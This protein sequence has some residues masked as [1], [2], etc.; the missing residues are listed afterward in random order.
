MPVAITKAT[1]DDI[2][3]FKTCRITVCSSTKG[4]GKSFF[5]MAMLYE[6]MRQ[7]AFD[8]YYV[9]I[10]SM[11][12]EENN[13]YGWLLARKDLTYS[14]SF[15]DALLQHIMDRQEKHAKSRVMLVMDDAT[16]WGS[17]MSSNLIFKQFITMSRHLRVNMVVAVHSL[18]AVLLPTIRSN[19]DRLIIGRTTNGRQLIS[20]YEE[21]SA[22]MPSDMK[23]VKKFIDVFTDKVNSQSNYNMMVLYMLRPSNTVE[24]TENMEF[25]SQYAEVFPTLQ[26]IKPPRVRKQRREGEESE[27]K[28]K[29]AIPAPAMSAVR[30]QIAIGTKR[31][32]ALLRYW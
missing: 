3:N 12:N 28:P 6:A 27:T 25:V 18:K 1:D 10:P 17:E 4:S 5:M 11:E 21:F 31:V 13:S 2:I 7:K 23:P 16:A 9:V 15:S 8:H 22:I 24:W 26:K 19:I 32:E 14:D 30:Q 20:I 29:S